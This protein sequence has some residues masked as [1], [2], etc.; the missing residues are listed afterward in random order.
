MD[1]ETNLLWF[2]SV[3]DETEEEKTFPG[4]KTIISPK[5]V[6]ER[7]STVSRLS[8]AALSAL[9]QGST[10]IMQNEESWNVKAEK[11]CALLNKLAGH[12]SQQGTEETKRCAKEVEKAVN[13]GKVT[14]QALPG[15]VCVMASGSELWR[16]QIG[17]CG[18]RHWLSHAA[19]FWMV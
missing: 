18:C 14:L 9:L 6:Q 8:P 19:M 4:E 12:W 5:A 7:F 16:M 3:W 11:V 2:T 15:C 13:D 17:V 1:Q 10:K